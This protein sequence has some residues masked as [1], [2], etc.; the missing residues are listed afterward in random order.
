MSVPHVDTFEHDIAEEIKTKE[1][2]LTD[3]ASAGGD[4]RNTTPAQTSNLLVIFGLLFVILVIAGV[5]WLLYIQV[6][7]TPVLP[8]ETATSTQTQNQNTLVKLSP[9]VYEAIG[10]SLGTI[11]KND[12]GYAIRVLSYSDAFSYMLRN[13][14]L[15]ADELAL[16]VGSPRDTTST[17]TLPFFFSDV[18]LSNQTMRVGTS[19]SSTVVYA[20]VNGATL[21]VSS[22]TSGILQ[23]RSGILTK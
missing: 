10:G 12:Y 8:S 17:T 16:A 13:E 15:Y 1:A 5:A 19:G 4:V 14:S 21:L 7:P 23:L 3:I 2:S 9:S 6:Q 22:S 11:T 18:T 20:F